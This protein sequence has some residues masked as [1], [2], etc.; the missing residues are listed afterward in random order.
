[1]EEEVEE[2]LNKK[3]LSTDQEHL[4]SMF[5]NYFQELGL[6]DDRK[7]PPP[8]APIILL[9]GDPGTGKSYATMTVIELANLTKSGLAIGTSY[10][11]IAAFNVDGQSLCQTLGIKGMVSPHS[12]TFISDE[13][14]KLLQTKLCTEKLVNLLLKIL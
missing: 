11:G 14:I 7:Q 8:K 1:M 4:V 2:F 12:S 9:T 3:T 6:H 13:K 5:K 10:N